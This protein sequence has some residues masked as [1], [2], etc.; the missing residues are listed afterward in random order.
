MRRKELV[1]VLTLCL[2]SNGWSEEILYR[3]EPSSTYTYLPSPWVAPE[4]CG[5]GS[6][7][8]TCQY[9]LEGTFLV[10]LSNV[11]GAEA[12][13]TMVSHDLRLVRGPVPYSEL[14]FHIAG[15]ILQFPTD[16]PSFPEE[17]LAISRAFSDLVLVGAADSNDGTRWFFEEQPIGDSYQAWIDG[18]RHLTVRGGRDGRGADGDGYIINVAASPVPEPRTTL[19]VGV[20]LLM[21]FTRRLGTAQRRA[22]RLQRATDSR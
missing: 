12:S 9:D 8:Y 20:L 2:S 16:V 13:L 11:D 10:D 3:V 1:F 5:A 18:N 4:N 6:P 15:D 14:P 7:P 21:V 22:Y 19:T 17:P